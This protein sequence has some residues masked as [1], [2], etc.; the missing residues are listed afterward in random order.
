MVLTNVKFLRTWSRDDPKNM[1]QQQ[2]NAS[3]TLC[4]RLSVYCT[5]KHT[6]HA[7]VRHSFMV[8][9]FKSECG[10]HHF[11]AEK[12]LLINFKTT[13]SRIVVGKKVANQN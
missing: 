1:K 7:M 2:L 3:I 10:S 6:F 12:K 8:F 13:F 9:V 5:S 4:M 11:A